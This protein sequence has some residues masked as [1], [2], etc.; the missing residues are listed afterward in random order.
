MST[1]SKLLQAAEQLNIPHRN[2]MLRE[3]LKKAVKDTIIR[4]KKTIF[5]V[6]S[7]TCINCVHELR[8]QQIINKN[9]Y[10]QKQ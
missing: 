3:N 9:V 1:L 10:D 7:P 6:D 4:Y 2:L 5:D 8:K